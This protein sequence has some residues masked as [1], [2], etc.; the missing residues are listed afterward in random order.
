MEPRETPSATPLLHVSTPRSGVEGRLADLLAELEWRGL[1]HD[2]SAGL[3]ERLASGRPLSAY[4]GF[5]PTAPSL[6]VGHLVPLFGLVRLQRHGVK[7]YALVGGAT[8]MVGDPSGR[9]AERVLLGR[10]VVDA[11]AAAIRA[12]ME[13]FLDFDEGPTQAVMANNLDWLG[14]VG[15][16]EFLRD[17]GK[18]F[19]IPYMLG[20][21]SVQVR[22]QG[23]LSFTEFSYMLLQSADFQHLYRE[24]GVELQAGGADQWGNITA[25]IELIRRTSGPDADQAHGL[26]YPLLLSPSGTKF[27]K[28]E[29]GDSVWLDP[30]STSPYRFYQYWVEADD[31]DV[32]LYLR[33][34]TLFD[35]EHVEALEAETAARPEARV[36]QR[37]L[38]QDLTERVHGADA[39]AEVARVSGILFGGDP[40]HADAATLAA[41][42]AE[43]PTAPWPGGGPHPATAIAIAA[44]AAASMSEARRLVSQGGLSVNGRT[45]R[46]ADERFG[47][48]DLLAERYLLVRKG[49]RDYRMLVRG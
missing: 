10:E 30:S 35:R 6:H 11:N 25:G 2:T 47:E 19:T 22:L 18:H 1:I 23:G 41:V 36:A 46:E 32:G 31:R 34:F 3:A 33:W 37:A 7:P 8:G 26:S 29:S 43:I 49:K 27:G 39:A 13:R 15:L 45:V 17:V 42:A 40:A 9:S 5:D 16:L 21:D 48:E 12:Q 38:A 28:S 44:G 4:N 14:G 20:K 24:H